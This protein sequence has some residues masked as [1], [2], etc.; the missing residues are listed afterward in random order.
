MLL[1]ADE[2]DNVRSLIVGGSSNGKTP[3]FGAGYLGSNP[4]PPV[5]NAKDGR[6]PMNSAKKRRLRNQIAERD[7]LHCIWCSKS[8][9][10][11]SSETTLDH[12]RPVADL[13]SWHVGNL[14]LACLACNAARANVDALDWLA[15]VVARGARPDLRAAAKAIS[16]ADDEL[17][18]GPYFAVFLRERSRERHAANIVNGRRRAR[19]SQPVSVA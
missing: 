6:I 2:Q 8:L 13:G 12:V 5:P 17:S 9:D 15:D 3:A 14:V 7:G 4:S 16:R 1:A 11:D 10:I 19:A 18:F